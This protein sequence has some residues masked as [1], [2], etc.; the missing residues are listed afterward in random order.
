MLSLAKALKFFGGKKFAPQTP[1]CPLKIDHVYW[2]CPEKP[3]E[4]PLY[5]SPLE[6]FSKKLTYYFSSA[7]GLEDGGGVKYGSSWYPRCPSQMIENGAETGKNGCFGGFL[8]G[9]P[10]VLEWAVLSCAG[11]VAQMQ[12]YNSTWAFFKIPTTGRVLWPSL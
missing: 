8:Y 6:E 9:A 7:S 10:Q 3:V 12:N 2:F 11:I 4:T 1:I 5:L